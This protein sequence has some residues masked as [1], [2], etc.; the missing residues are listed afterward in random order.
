[1]SLGTDHTI[2]KTEFVEAM[3]S[4][5]AS[6][7]PDLGETVDKPGAQKNL[8]AFGLAVYRIATAHAEVVSEAV[9]DTQFWQ[10]IGALEEWLSA[11]SAWQQGMTQT[12]AEWE[13]TQPTDQTL[14]EAISNLREPGLPPRP[15]TRLRGRIE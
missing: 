15:P 13:P 9:T 6:D 8:G 10:W 4:R 12:F 3:R 5:L 1:M 11:L 7:R 2:C 14:Q